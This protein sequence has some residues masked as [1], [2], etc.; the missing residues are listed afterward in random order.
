[1]LPDSSLSSLIGESKGSLI[2]SKRVLSVTHRMLGLTWGG[3]EWLF[4]DGPRQTVTR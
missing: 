2:H 4:L 3:Q 1:M